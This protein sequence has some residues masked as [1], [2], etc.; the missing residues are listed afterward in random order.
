MSTHYRDSLTTDL[1][2]PHDTGHSVP[3]EELS[4]LRFRFWTVESSEDEREKQFMA[5]EEGLEFAG[6]SRQGSVTDLAKVDTKSAEDEAKSFAQDVF[7]LKDGM[8]FI[9]G[10]KCYHDFKGA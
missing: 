9:K 6:G 2:L 7:V 8:I 3:E 1:S 5:F 4:A 10:G